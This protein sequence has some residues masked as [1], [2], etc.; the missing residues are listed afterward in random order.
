MEWLGH[1]IRLVIDSGDWSHIHLSRTGQPLSHKDELI[2]FGHMDKRQ[3]KIIKGI[4]DNFCN[5]LGHKINM[6]KTN[7]FFSKGVDGTL[8]RCI[9]NI[10]SY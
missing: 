10:F 8:E 2:L 5:F 6:Q 7:I 4:L 9:S 1:S 3:V